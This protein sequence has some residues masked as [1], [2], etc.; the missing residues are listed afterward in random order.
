MAKATNR[1]RIERIS[2]AASH[3]ALSEDVIAR[4]LKARVGFQDLAAR[5]SPLS[6]GNAEVSHA[7]A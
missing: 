4:R 5:P 3:W 2:R 1:K 6:L 7:A